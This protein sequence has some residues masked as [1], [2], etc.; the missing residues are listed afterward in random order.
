MKLSLFKVDSSG[1]IREWEISSDPEMG[2]LRMASGVQGG[3]KIVSHE[4]VSLNESGRNLEEQVELRLLS[5]ANKKRRSG[6]KNSVEEARA[7]V[8]TNKVGNLRPMLAHKLLIGK[9]KAKRKV[10][11]VTARIQRK[12]EGHRC[13][14]GCKDGENYAYSR[15]GEPILSIDHI[16]EEVCIPEGA[17]IDG[18]LYVHGM[19]L[20]QI[21]SVVR[22]PQPM[23]AQLKFMA[24]DIVDTG[25][26][27]IDR[28]E[29]LR[30][31]FEES[32]FGSN[33]ILVP[34][35]KVRDYEE[36]VALFMQFRA[37]GY[38]GAIV[39]HGDGGYDPG[40]RSVFLLKMKSVEDDHFLVTAIS[41]SKD[42]WAIC[43]CI[44]KDGVG[45]KA[46][47]PGTVDAKEEVLIN[48]ENYIGKMLHVEFAFYSNDG[49]PFQPIATTWKHDE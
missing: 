37:E 49:T 44:T 48:S 22:K 5:R 10:V 40:N 11:W 42:G 6:Y 31:L 38:E 43:H 2:T 1:S 28:H 13:L 9:K 46:S 18:E 47:A 36:A 27:Y 23:S 15:G 25:S 26:C 4:S 45:F 19:K 34:T 17:L 7:S 21:N 12:Y 8:G 14:I 35:Y 32:S 29:T 39:R 16:L 24:Y 30:E 3:S 41:A 20:Q 33:C